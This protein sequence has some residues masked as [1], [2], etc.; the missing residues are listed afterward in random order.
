LIISCVE[1]SKDVSDKALSCPNCGVPI[2]VESKVMVY[3]YTQ[4]FAVNPAVEVFWQG[5]SIGKVKQAD[6][7]EFPITEDGEV[8]FKCNLRRASLIVRAGRV[9]KIK[10]SWNRLTGKLV[11]QF[12]DGIV[13]S[14]DRP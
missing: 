5:R 14:N 7:L 6:L 12:V 1:C 8:A 10:I 9:N 4:Q 13:S 2:Q 11:P 3:G